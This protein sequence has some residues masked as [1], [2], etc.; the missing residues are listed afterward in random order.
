VIP[1]RA[2][3]VVNFRILP[4]ESIESVLEHV[5][6]IVSD[7]R[8]HVSP[9]LKRREPSPISRIDSE[10]YAVLSRTIR[11]VFPGT[12]VAPYLVVGGS[13]LRHFCPLTEDVY[14]FLPFLLS[15]RDLKGIHGTDERVPI[16]GLATGVRFYLRLLRNAAGRPVAA[17]AGIEA[18]VEAAPSM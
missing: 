8:V 9:L 3:A 4:G 5:G 11:E 12:I 18:P 13:D 14:R 7:D 10:H 6:R 2:R 1:R 16:E 15:E 17:E